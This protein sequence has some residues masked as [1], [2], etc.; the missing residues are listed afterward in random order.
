MTHLEAFS[1][2]VTRGTGGL[3][4][5]ECAASV[6]QYADPDFAP[7]DVVR[8]V[9]AWGRQLAARI[10]ADT[11][12]ANRLRLLNHFFF[13]ELAFGPG[14]ADYYSVDN[15]YL[16]RVVERRR[17]IPITLSLLYMEVGRA[18][19]LKLAGVNFPGHFLVRL[20]VGDNA[21]LIDVYG[22]GITLSAAQLQARAAK[23][24]PVAAE[25]P[26]EL[27]LRPASARD[28]LARLLRNLKAIHARASDWTALLEVQHRLVLL[29]PDAPEERRD[30][31]LAFEKLECPRAAVDDL[32]AYLSLHPD[33]PDVHEMRDRLA[34]LQRRAQ[35]LN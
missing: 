22:H 23:A 4:L 9:E 21:L 10:A 6:P 18:I 34:R 15:S 31:A 14:D 19:G 7:A 5:L 20:P 25:T 1:T 33:P 12:P 30:R 8:Q 3:P 16:H 2:L 32:V 11:S 13:D 17:G 26:L 29:A 27:H 28:I 24:G 35:R